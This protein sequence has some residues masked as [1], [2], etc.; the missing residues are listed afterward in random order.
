MCVNRAVDRVMN[1]IA[2]AP[3]ENLP[4]LEAIAAKVRARIA[5][6][7]LVSWCPRCGAKCEAPGA[8]FACGCGAVHERVWG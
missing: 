8:T 6:S 7:V 1:I 3:A 2:D 5:V 4:A